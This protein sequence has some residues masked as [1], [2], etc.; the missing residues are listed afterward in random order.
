MLIVCYLFIHIAFAQIPTDNPNTNDP[1]WQLKWKDDFNSFDNIKW[2]K[3]HYCDHGDCERVNE[4][5][6]HLEENVWVADSNLVIKIAN[7]G[8][9]CPPCGTYTVETWA[10]GQCHP[11]WHYYTSGWA[12]TKYD[13]CPQF[14]YIEAKIKLPYHTGYYHHAFWTWAREGS[15]NQAEIDIFEMIGTLPPNTVTTNIHTCYPNPKKYPNPED[16]PC[17]ENYFQEQILPGFNYTDW[18]TYAIEWNSKKITWFVDGK[19][20]R[21]LNNHNIIDHVRIILGSGIKNAPQ[22]PPFVDYWYVDYVKV[23]DL[24]YD[25]ANNASITNTTQLAN[26][27]YKVKNS[28]TLS[29]ANTIQAGDNVC[30]RAVNS[31]E[32]L[33]GFEVPPGAELYLDNTPCDKPNTSINKKLQE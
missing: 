14:G 15:T 28:I 24:K 21:T 23:Y 2:L 17:K 27:D 18:H 6:L 8:A 5:Q 29:G 22:A 11:G 31:I 19:T 10:C 1:H 25:C 16:D 33:D 12:E 26:Y 3:A 9:N 20:I 30:L 4:P 32:L 13:Y 7:D